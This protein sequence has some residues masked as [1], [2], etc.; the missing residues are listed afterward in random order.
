MPKYDPL[1]TAV[2]AYIWEPEPGKDSSIPAD[3]SH[4]IKVEPVTEEY[5]DNKRGVDFLGSS[6]YPFYLINAGQDLFYGGGIPLPAENLT[7][8]NR[9]GVNPEIKSLSDGSKPVATLAPALDKQP[10][11]PVTPNNGSESDLDSLLSSIPSSAFFEDEPVPSLDGPN[12]KKRSGLNPGTHYKI[13]EL[14]YLNGSY[15]KERFASR[16]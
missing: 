1:D 10:I 16:S 11:D 14:M 12:E 2:A 5:F 4:G 9:T 13:S 6:S 7:C 3:V 8:S 15:K